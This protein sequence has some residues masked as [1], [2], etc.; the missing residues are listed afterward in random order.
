MNNRLLDW[1]YVL[2]PAASLE[3]S[4]FSLAFFKEG[5][6]VIEIFK[7][8]APLRKCL[9][10]FLEFADTNSPPAEFDDTVKYFYV[11]N[12]LLKKR[13]LWLK[14]RYCQRD[15]CWVEPATDEIPSLE[16]T[17]SE[18]NVI[19]RF[20]FIRRVDFGWALECPDA[21][22]R[23]FPVSSIPNFFEQRDGN[24]LD[25][26]SL[27]SAWREIFD[28]FGFF[29]Q[30]KTAQGDLTFTEFH[31]RVF[32]WLS[33]TPPG[34]QEIGGTY[35]FKKRGLLPE[36]YRPTHKTIPLP[37]PIID[38]K[39]HFENAS[40]SSVLSKR[41]TNRTAG[42][43]TFEISQLGDLLYY[44]VRDIASAG[45]SAD[46]ILHRPY[47]SGG[48]IHEISFY[49]WAR[50][51]AGLPKDLYRY[52]NDMHALEPLSVDEQI[53]DKILE[54]AAA[55]IPPYSGIPGLMISIASNISAIAYKYEGLA[56][57]I[58]QFNAG[59]ALQT[60]LLVGEAMHL[61]CCPIGMVSAELMQKTIRNK[62]FEELSLLD[63][64]VSNPD[65]KDTKW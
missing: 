30:N 63:V 56:Y 39:N 5:N 55:S 42:L 64:V 41:R 25:D 21:L 28:V 38:G 33:R 59:C 65:R 57:R 13:C 2:N 26:D 45:E 60:L 52:W 23:I 32:H 24:I 46:G 48:A 61:A 11:I 20:S 36:K 8:T 51:V 16:T 62:G 54:S 19:S 6:K 9:I 15:L 18:C 50:N 44:S 40:L 37:M 22:G 17:L 53:V 4:D 58:S 27:S 14:A 35:R 1:G 29:E 7:P 10:Q 3:S 47:P 43:T 34:W 12:I 49:I 31:D